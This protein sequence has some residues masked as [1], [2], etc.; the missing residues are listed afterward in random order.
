MI[1]EPVTL[2]PDALVADALELM[3]RYRI[4]GVPITDDDGVLVGILTNRDLRFETNVRAAGLGADDRARPRH[5][6]GRHDARGGE[7]DPPPAQDR[8]AAGRRRGRPAPGPDHRQGHPEADRV[9]ARDEGRARPAAR[10]RR[11]RRRHRRV[12]ARRARS[13]TPGST[14]SS[15]TPR[16][17]TRVGV[18]EMVR[19]IKSECDVEVIA[20]NIATAE[21]AEALIDAGA[22]AV[23][24]GIGPGLDLHDA[25][26]RRRRRAA[27]HG[28][29]RRA[30][31]SRSGT[32]CR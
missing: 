4:S 14:C 32:A 18:V 2:R 11:R 28:R 3:A 27:G 21:A 16:T 15:S 23:K 24:V 29:L 17:G 1:V 30:P 22:D 20:G 9:P 25:R 19:R 6:A 13:S 12:R 7:R 5:R 26:R 10:R 31:R 8:E